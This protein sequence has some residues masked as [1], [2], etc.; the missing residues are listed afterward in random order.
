MC[1][2]TTDVELQVHRHEGAGAFPLL[3]ARGQCEH[4]FLCSTEE[5]AKV[6]LKG[7]PRGGG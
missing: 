6:S 7:H 5:P 3:P 1:E 4:G 2:K